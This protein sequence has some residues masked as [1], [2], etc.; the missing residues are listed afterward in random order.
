MSAN[1]PS[2]PSSP[3]RPYLGI[4]FECCNVYTRIYKNK[5]GTAYVGRCPRCGK[6]VTIP[7]DPS[8][9]AGRFFS[10]Y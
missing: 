6:K 10:A 1:P 4:L 3:D 5:A 8:G 7:I 2:S 9:T